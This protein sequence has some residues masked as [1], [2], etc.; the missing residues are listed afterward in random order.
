MYSLILQREEG[1]K[2]YLEAYRH[3]TKNFNSGNDLFNFPYFPWCGKNKKHT[4]RPNKETIGRLLFESPEEIKK[5]V[6]PCKVLTAF[7]HVAS[8]FLIKTEKAFLEH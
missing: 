5:E 2:G 8:S 6:E 4:T 3:I 1:S 7:P